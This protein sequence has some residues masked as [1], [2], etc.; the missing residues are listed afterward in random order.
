[1]AEQYTVY[2]AE[3]VTAGWGKLRNEW[4]EPE[5]K[6]RKQKALHHMQLMCMMGL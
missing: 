5:C 1:M 2:L 3:D 6:E 4:G